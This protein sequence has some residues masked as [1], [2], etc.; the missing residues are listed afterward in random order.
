MLFYKFGF[1]KTVYCF[2]Q[3]WREKCFVLNL[4]IRH[5]SIELNIMYLF[6]IRFLGVVG[7]SKRSCK[8]F[9][10]IHRMHTKQLHNVT[11]ISAKRFIEQGNYI[12]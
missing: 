8:R 1:Q 7:K 2:F 4:N 9:E 12:N 10:D 5:R 3:T 11:E 6:C